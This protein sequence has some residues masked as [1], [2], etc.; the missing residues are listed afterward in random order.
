MI[1]II[2]DNNNDKDKDNNDNRKNKAV[3]VRGPCC[4]FGCCCCSCLY[5]GVSTINHL[6]PPSLYFLL[7]STSPTH[8]ASHIQH[9][10][11]HHSSSHTP[12]RSCTGRA[13]YP[14]SLFTTAPLDT[15]LASLSAFPQPPPPGRPLPT[16]AAPL[17]HPVLS[18]VG[19]T[20]ELPGGRGWAVKDLH[21]S[22]QA[23]GGRAAV[24]GR[25]GCGKTTLCRAL[26]GLRGL[27]GGNV[28]MPPRDKVDGVVWR[29]WQ[30][31][32]GDMS[33]FC[34]VDP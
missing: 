13:A 16:A 29:C 24:M 28:V 14:A 15:L 2:D 34:V 32:A 31:V 25:S 19:L 26:A 21:L 20:C 9:P 6:V 12:C 18:L 33:R 17:T 27:R 5:T 23:G 22:L 11:L 4:P 30:F 8:C 10:I 1:I 7:H 3:G